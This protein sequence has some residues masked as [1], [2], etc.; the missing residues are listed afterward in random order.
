[1][2]TTY[3][4]PADTRKA[5]NHLSSGKCRSKPQGDSISD[6]LGCLLSKTQE[7]TYDEE[8]G[9]KDPCTCW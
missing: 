9:I 2:K 1:M 5:Q 8:G 7:I 4:R 6:L 3:K